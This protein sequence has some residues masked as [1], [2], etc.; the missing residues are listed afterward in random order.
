MKFSLVKV[1]IIS[2]TFLSLILL[3]ISGGFL[4]Q[5]FKPLSDLYLKSNS[6]IG[7]DYYNGL[8]YLKYISKYLPFPPAGW[9]AFWH[10][11][12]PIIG[13]YLTTP[14]YITSLLTKT[15]D[16]AS[17]M[18]IFNLSTLFLF[19]IGSLILFWIVTRNAPFSFL[20][21]FIIFKT[22]ATY[23]QAFAEG[24]MLGSSGQWLM[25]ITLIF[26]YLYLK[27]RNSRALVLAAITSGLA[28]LFHP[29]IGL[30]SSVIPSFVLLLSHSLLTQ[31]KF[32][33][34][35]KSLFIFSIII[36]TTGSIS[37]YSI[38]L[39]TVKRTGSGACN[40][41][42]CW[43]LYPDHITTWLNNIYLS[44]GILIILIFI[45]LII[46]LVK[47]EK[48]SFK[49]IAAFISAFFVLIL[50]PISTYFHLINGFASAIFPRRIFWAINLLL[51]VTSATTFRQIRDFLGHRFSP[52]LSF[53]AI[54]AIFL[55]YSSNPPK[56]F[57]V[58]YLYSTNRPATI[59]YGV[60][61]SIL[62][63]Y[64]KGDLTELVPSWVVDIAKN[65]RNFRMDSLNNQLNH[66]WN[67][68]FEMPATR[69]YSNNPIGNNA[70]WLY[71]LQVGTAENKK[72]QDPELTKNKTLFLIDHFGISLY[73]DSQRSASGGK[74]GYDLSLLQDKTIFPRVESKR[75]LSF[76]EV[77]K[78]FTS[79]VVSPTNASTTL[80]I[81][82]DNG[83][84][85]LVR[86]LS[87]T[88]LNSKKIITVAGPES[89]A[90]V[91]TK[92]LNFFDSI[93]L[94]RYKGGDLNK[95]LGFLERGGKVYI[96]ANE[97]TTLPNF[98]PVKSIKSSLVKGKLNLKVE[99]SELLE[100]VNP[101]KFSEFSFENGPWK[102]TKSS[103][104]ELNKNAKA[105]VSTD[106]EIL[107]ASNQVGKGQIIVS[108]FNLPFHVVTS[109]NLNEINLLKNILTSTSNFPLVEPVFT[110]TRERPEKIHLSGQQFK[111]IYIKENFNSGWRAL[112]RDTPQG[113]TIGLKVYKAGLDFMFIPIFESKNRTIDV[114]LNF[115][116]NFATW[117]LFLITIA[118]ILI[119]IIFV[120]Y[121]PLFNWIGLGI[122]SLY[123]KLLGGRLSDWIKEE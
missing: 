41:P 68:P 108:G 114:N 57:D 5:I 111:G 45:S 80:V 21:A 83:Y 79:P 35:L 90:K 94:Y 2:G 46:K 120:I 33:K 40:S 71:Y 74:L 89:L 86:A 12:I 62:S 73:E 72:D 95:L 25:P 61:T 47:P 104:G 28:T 102:I 16:L 78:D 99:S 58:S 84:E 92:E 97:E 76:F 60:H 105:Q 3:G 85:T 15:F 54:L 42:Q 9:L 10:E 51:L 11:G 116:G 49:I 24:L 106:S 96:E 17:S 110:F 91:S 115:S 81:S 98:F 107:L 113:K 123:K 22:K 103:K 82:D 20:L 119:S 39:L 118:S 4:F 101:S 65:E 75:E 31:Q 18:E 32:R 122:R 121:P 38:Y 69:G 56:F 27:N 19:I 87:L 44:I 37:L 6:P 23:Y 53:I 77:S 112:R 100:N 13:G 67:I 88:G 117:S 14:F 26:V 66:W 34:T 48:F 50:Y 64:G 36:T 52:I 59:P 93:I 1:A 70:N 109:E 7:S 8:T 55:L 43:G 63:K 29:A 30:L